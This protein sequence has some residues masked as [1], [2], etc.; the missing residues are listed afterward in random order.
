M[1]EYTISRHVVWVLF[2]TILF[3]MPAFQGSGD[4][5]TRGPTPDLMI[6]DM[7]LNETSYLFCRVKNLGGFLDDDFMINL[8]VNDQMLY[9]LMLTWNNFTGPN[10][11]NWPEPLPWIADT[12]VVE[13]SLFYYTSTQ[14]ANLSNNVKTEVWTRDIEEPDYNFRNLFVRSVSVD[15]ETKEVF[16]IIGNDGME[17][18]NET[19][20]VTLSVDGITAGIGNLTTI[21]NRS[22]VSRV[23]LNYIWPESVEEVNILVHADPGDLINETDEADNFLEIIWRSSMDLEFISGPTVQN[24]TLNSAKIVFET[25]VPVS[26]KLEYGIGRWLTEKTTSA[27]TSTKG[28]IILEGLDPRTQY[29][30][31]AKVIDTIGRELT[32]KTNYFTT[33][34]F[35][36]IAPTASF[37][38][39]LS[40]HQERVNLPLSVEDD[41]GIEKIVLLLDGEEHSCVGGMGTRSLDSVPFDLT[42]AAEGEHTVTATVYDLD[43]HTYV[44]E[45]DLTITIDQQLPFGRIEFTTHYNESVDGIVSLGAECLDMY[46]IRNATWHINGDV[47]KN[48]ENPSCSES[49]LTDTMWDTRFYPNGAQNITLVMTNYRRMEFSKTIWVET[50][51]IFSGE[52]AIIVTR[53]MASSKGSVVKSLLFVKNVGGSPV[54]D[55]TIRDTVKGFVPFDGFDSCSALNDNGTVWEVELSIDLLEVNDTTQ[56]SYNCIPILHGP[57]VWEFGYPRPHSY[58]GM[59]VIM[60]T[61]KIN[62]FSIDGTIEYTRYHSLYSPHFN[63]GYGIRNEIERMFS[64][65]SYLL[66]TCPPRLYDNYFPGGDVDD[67]L[68]LGAR[69]LAERGGVYAFPSLL[70]NG[71]ITNVS[72]YADLVA[73]SKIISEEFGTDG[74]LAILGEDEIIPAWK[75]NSINRVYSDLPYS[76]LNGGIYQNIFIGRF[77][78]NSLHGF[79]IQLET[80]LG[81]ANG[82]LSCDNQGSALLI[83]GIGDF[84][85]TFISTAEQLEEELEPYMESVEVHHRSDFPQSYSHMGSWTG[86]DHHLTAGDV[87]NDG[88]EEAVYILHDDDQIEILDLDTGSSRTL[89][90]DCGYRTQICAGDL[91]PD[92]GD[93]IVVTDMVDGNGTV[94]ILDASGDI[95]DQFQVPWS[96]N[97]PTLVMDYDGEGLDEYLF[98]E[99]GEGILLVFDSTGEQIDSIHYPGVTNYGKLF[100]ADINNDGHMDIV[101]IDRYMR[102]IQLYIGPDMVPQNISMEYYM[103][104]GTGIGPFLP[105]GETGV[106]T[107][108]TGY[109]GFMMVSSFEYDVLTEQYYLETKYEFMTTAPGGSQVEIAE[110]DGSGPAAEIVLVVGAEIQEISYIDYDEQIGDVEYPYSNPFTDLVMD[111]MSGKDL[112][113]YYDHGGTNEWC[114]IFGSDQARFFGFLDS[115]VRPVIYGCACLTGTYTYSN[116]FAE[117]CM[118]NGAGVYIGAFNIAYLYPCTESREFLVDYV[119]GQPLCVALRNYKRQ[120]I[121]EMDEESY[122]DPEHL[123]HWALQFNYFGD[124]AFGLSGNGYQ[125]WEPDLGLSGLEPGSFEDVIRILKPEFRNDLFEHEAYIPGGFFEILPDGTPIPYDVFEYAV[126]EGFVVE[127]VMIQATGAW[128]IYNDVFISPSEIM[129]LEGEPRT[130]TS[131]VRGNDDPLDPLGSWSNGSFSWEVLDAGNGKQTLRIS[132]HPFQYDDAG[133]MA[134]FCS[135]WQINIESIPSNVTITDL[136]GPSEPLEPGNTASFSFEIDPCGDPGDISISTWIED[137]SGSL[138]ETVSGSFVNINMTTTFMEKWITGGHDP[139]LYRFAVEMRNPNGTLL[140]VTRYPFMLGWSSVSIEDL[141]L[142]SEEYDNTTVIDFSTRVENTGD[143]DLIGDIS[144]DL[145]GLN[146]SL[147]NVMDEQITLPAGSDHTVDLSIGMSGFSQNSYM[148][149]VSFLSDDIRSSKSSIIF[150]EGTVSEPEE[151]YLMKMELFLPSDQPVENGSFSLRGVIL[152]SD[153]V[154]LGNASIAIWFDTPSNIIYAK[155][156]SN[157]SFNVTLVAPSAGPH[158][159]YLKARLGDLSAEREL[160][161]EVMETGTDDDTDDDIEDDDSVDDDVVDDDGDRELS[162]FIVLLILGISIFVILIAAVLVSMVVLKKRGKGSDDWDME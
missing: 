152:R 40:F 142:S 89:D 109:D 62:F 84:S 118:T 81:M 55:V 101:I 42:D 75:V 79:Q 48:H 39:G 66:L 38:S 146:G 111:E 76:N 17:Q 71:Q 112:I 30:Y 13:M 143:I 68:V 57:N 102:V 119:E 132:I 110:V 138:L 18:I 134:R 160:Q 27:N 15:P 64:H 98:Y 25:S 34:L 14:D 162:G 6:D 19:V 47:I 29:C 33:S 21:L 116:S 3:S 92:P 74:F 139:G 121:A 9:P 94:M 157:G 28:D 5:G 159:L 155:T 97:E 106:A 52:P 44:V 24:V 103:I 10:D 45:T 54:R 141:V 32:S 77:I 124:P 133:M 104:Q 53:G 58:G 65:V 16:T 140:Q 113:Y 148:I 100:D 137:P 120:L 96:F 127:D 91:H 56:V 147:E 61:T 99:T 1:K 2:I 123:G 78:G 153:D 41:K 145:M 156:A 59:A 86:M 49:F 144:V 50:L 117:A 72:V 51:N 22:E 35:L 130:R 43:G 7:W 154:P 69:L 70:P 135:E 136:T 115:N 150:R 161:L 80:A 126:P 107:I 125:D 63:S 90:H 105:G 37:G 67:I 129:E 149:R 114:N 87:D 83:S 85:S 31:R 131:V 36:G 88:K 128:D 73:W 151:Q 82:D 46:G 60:Y 4:T 26:C 108:F 122:Y 11:Y 12:M 158:V 93:E 8:K 23:D 95:L 20:P